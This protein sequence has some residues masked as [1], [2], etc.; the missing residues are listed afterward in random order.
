VPGDD[1]IPVSTHEGVFVLMGFQFRC[2]QLS[3]GQR[4]FNADDV[5]AFY[6][7]FFSPEF[8]DTGTIT[9]PKESK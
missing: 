2:Y 4:V 1:G 8:A 3:N 6:A 5:E 9:P 7:K